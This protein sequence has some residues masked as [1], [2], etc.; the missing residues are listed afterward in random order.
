[1]LN[2]LPPSERMR[3][4]LTCVIVLLFVVTLWLKLYPSVLCSFIADSFCVRRPNAQPA[5]LPITTK[6]PAPAPPTTTKAAITPAAP[7][8]KAAPATS[9][10]KAVVDKDDEDVPDIVDEGPD[11]DDE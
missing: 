8:S 2:P 5:N 4:R 3:I 11:S 6:A 7:A 9:T 10:K 1:M